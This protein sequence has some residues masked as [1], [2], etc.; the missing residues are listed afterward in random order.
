MHPSLT[1]TSSGWRA[2]PEGGA[3]CLSGWGGVCVVLRSGPPA[4]R[5][6]LCLTKRTP[7]MNLLGLASP[8]HSCVTTRWVGVVCAKCIWCAFRVDVPVGVL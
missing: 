3:A 7:T 1:T 4:T 5:T 6:G 8:F 2:P